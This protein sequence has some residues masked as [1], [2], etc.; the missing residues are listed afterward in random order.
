MPRP[1]KSPAFDPP[2]S[3]VASAARMTAKRKDRPLGTGPEPWQLDAW[4][5]F[6]TCGELAFSSQ[7]QAN[8]MSQV[9]LR[10]VVE[11]PDGT[12]EEV[13]DDAAGLGALAV[14]AMQALF[15]GDTGQAQMM[16]AL[17]VH[18]SVP[19]ESYLVGL[20]PDEADGDYGRD[21][22]RV[23]SNEELRETSPGSGKWELD[24]GDGII[25]HLDVN[26]NA[27]VQALIIRIWRNHPRKAVLATSPV[28]AALPVLH[29]LEGLT[30]HV[31]STID[32]RLAGAGILLVPSEMT[33]QTP[34]T[35]GTPPTDA[36]ADQFLAELGAAM[37]A[38]LADQGSP[39]ARVPIVVKAPGQFLQ[40]VQ[41]IT[42]D[43]PLDDKALALR[44]EAIRRLA[45]SLDMPP[46]VLLG[47]A[48][49]NHWS[50]WLISEDAIK[51]HIE[52]LAG[53]VVDAL[54]SRYLWP[55]MQGP[56][57]V[58]DPAIKR[59]RLQ[60][61]TSKLRQR[62]LDVSQAMAMHAAFLISDEA[63]LR[64]T[65]FDPGDAPTDA[66]RQRRFTELVASGAPGPD[67]VAA[68]INIVTGGVVVPMPS[69]VDGESGGPNPLEGSPPPTLAAPPAAPQ[70][71]PRTPPQAAAAALVA[72][73][74]LAV[75]RAVERAWNRAGR[76]GAE[77]RAVPAAGLDAALAGAW[78]TIPRVAA[79]L[80][81]DP[82]RL[83]SAL[84]R[85]AR[86]LLETGA[87]HD[88][89]IFNRLLSEQVL[90]APRQLEAVG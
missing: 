34:L 28:R 51:I 43:S 57:R 1:K 22:W 86:G 25:E 33:F 84:D 90:A 39:A 65:R 30:K 21:M 72:C 45:L 36:E 67:I 29:E 55:A 74:E 75:F 87:A 46:E 24:R 15:D 70:E 88:P 37:A 66:E 54:V 3:F 8:A 5:F 76:R 48:D 59:Y 64:E 4:H 41:H 60:A 63:L 9:T 19:G 78:D 52:P 53:L 71:A 20:P 26:E 13:K 62:S 73:G 89:A 42:F 23:V 44:E 47:Q 69:T 12:V 11:M 79:Q 7:W 81:V 83:H 40:Y 58:M 2:N 31:A 18:L 35:D 56:S 10:L 38:A 17:G 32:S 85:Y 77:R 16:A 49:S 61:D 14:E 6:D 82:E 68:A 50:A 27:Q 80:G